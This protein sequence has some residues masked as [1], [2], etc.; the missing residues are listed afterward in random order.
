MFCPILQ[1]EVRL[2]QQSSALSEA[3]FANRISCEAFH[4][5]PHVE[6]FSA[7]LILG[8]LAR[9]FIHH[10]LDDGLQGI[11]FLLGEKG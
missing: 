6:W 8:N 5:V 3:I 10:G 11:D 2:V 1:G 9:E 7:L 4:G